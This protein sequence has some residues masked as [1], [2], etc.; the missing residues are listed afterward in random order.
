MDKQGS[1]HGG[2]R[3]EVWK[4]LAEWS[5]TDTAAL[6]ENSAM[7][8]KV[9][10]AD[11]ARPFVPY[12]VTLLIESREDHIVFHD[13]VACQIAKSGKFIGAVYR[14]GREKV[15]EAGDVVFQ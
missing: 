6:L 2:Q 9:E 14:A 3:S 12:E 5:K 1:A 15:S 13:K 11:T 10:T 8:F 7:K 4:T